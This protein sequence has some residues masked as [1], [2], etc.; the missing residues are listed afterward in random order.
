MAVVRSSRPGIA[1]NNHTMVFDDS[2]HYIIV[3]LCLQL[4]LP[5]PKPGVRKGCAAV[6]YA[7]SGAAA[8]AAE[9][10]DD[11]EAEFGRYSS[12]F[13]ED[14]DAGACAICY[15]LHL[16]DPDKP[17]ELGEVLMCCVSGCCV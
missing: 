7:A 12:D 14:D 5:A 17:D 13:E 11:M 10:P 4:H 6:Q 8:A 15:S 9:G 3:D 2:Q 1:Q 16:P